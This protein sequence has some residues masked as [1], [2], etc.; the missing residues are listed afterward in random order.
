MNT[1]GHSSRRTQV[2]KILILLI[3][4]S[5]LY[6]LA[7]VV[8]IVCLFIPLPSGSDVSDYMWPISTH[9]AG[10]YP[11]ILLLLIAFKR[12]IW[13]FSGNAPQVILSDIRYASGGVTGVQQRPA[14]D[15]DP[16]SSDCVRADE[17]KPVSPI[18]TP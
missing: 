11:T 2:E 17:S 14:S 9:I 5:V 15:R 16:S 3:E 10:I 8:L 18:D 1:L 6:C 4:S 12:T 13:D 7:W